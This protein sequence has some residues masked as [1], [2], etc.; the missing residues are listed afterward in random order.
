M[1]IFCPLANVTAQG[2][3]IRCYMQVVILVHGSDNL[4]RTTLL[5]NRGSWERLDAALRIR[6]EEIRFMSP[7]CLTVETGYPTTRRIT[8]LSNLH[9][10]D[11]QQL[12]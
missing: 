9:T 11:N 12:S 3:A 2:E 5:P 4:K 8:G 10:T 1:C 6:L 7:W